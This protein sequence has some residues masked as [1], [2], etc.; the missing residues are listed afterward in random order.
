MLFWLWLWVF[1]LQALLP[2]LSLE[3]N[4]RAPILGALEKALRRAKPHSA[5]HAALRKVRAR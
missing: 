2:V 3:H 5:T 1:P 4:Q